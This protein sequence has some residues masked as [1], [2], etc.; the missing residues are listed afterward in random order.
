MPL[1]KIFLSVTLM[2]FA[3]AEPFQPKFYAFQNGV[4][5]KDEAATLKELGFDGISQVRADQKGLPKKVAAFEAAGMKVLSIYLNVNDQ[6]LAAETVQALA[7]R[8]AF[9]ELTIQK[10]TPETVEAVRQTAE[11][12][13]KLKIKVALYPHDGF[14]VATM[15]Q[16]MDLIEKVNHANLGVMFNLCHFLKNEDPKSLESSL[17]NAGP[18]L[19]AV[20]TSGADL[21]GKIWNELIQTLD[22]GDFP[23][24]RLFRALKSLDFKGPVGL[25]CYAIKGD[26]RQNLRNSMAAWKTLIKD[27]D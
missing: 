2:G 17:K 8:D 4:N 5:F 12:A 23:Q 7:N 18:K 10:M 6:P 3:L 24:K 16:A 21:D 15:P 20:S 14:A 25:Q 13:A 19:F 26:K 22:Q 1:L 9:I 27:L 11:M